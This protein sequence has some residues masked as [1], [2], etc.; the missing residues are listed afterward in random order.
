MYDHALIDR[1][2]LDIA[3]ARAAAPWRPWAAAPI[4]L[5]RQRLQRLRFAAAPA[6]RTPD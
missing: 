4:R 5:L 6:G 1:S 3:R 2:L